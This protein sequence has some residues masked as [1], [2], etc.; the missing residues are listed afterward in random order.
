[1][2]KRI[3]NAVR[4]KKGKIKYSN[5]PGTRME[6]RFDNINDKD[7]STAFIAEIM[8]KTGKGKDKIIFEALFDMNKKYD[9]KGNLV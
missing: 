9:N 6:I 1:M 3:E 5:V 4:D 2:R 8:R 7:M